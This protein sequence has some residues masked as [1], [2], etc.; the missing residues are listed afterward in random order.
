MAAYIKQEQEMTQAL[1]KQEIT[2]KEFTTLADS[3]A[4][5]ATGRHLVDSWNAEV[6]Q[7][8]VETQAAIGAADCNVS[9]L[10]VHTAHCQ[11]TGIQ[12]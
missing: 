9:A 8:S 2:R 12:A 3:C 1:M 5:A 7:G 6:K 4:K 10:S 11:A